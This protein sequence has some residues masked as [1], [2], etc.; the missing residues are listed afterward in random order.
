MRT[1]SIYIDEQLMEEIKKFACLENRNPNN[2][3]VTVL[4]KEIKA[5]KII[6][7]RSSKNNDLKHENN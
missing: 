1:T 4:K 2:Y 5:Q 3:I 7:S 6:L